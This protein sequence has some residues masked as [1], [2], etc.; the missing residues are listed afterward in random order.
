MH[1]KKAPIE[2]IET[3]QEC[4]NCG[5]VSEDIEIATKITEEWL[6][7]EYY[8]TCNGRNFKYDLARKYYQK[9]LIEMESGNE[10]AAFNT[11]IHASW[12][13]EDSNDEEN[14]LHYQECSKEIMRS[15]LM[16][17]LLGI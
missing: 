16:K 9:Y 2:L 3:I 11:S 4:P 5:Y 14:M 13:T 1:F 6:Q 10:E 8:T 7:S 17:D 15:I 12:L